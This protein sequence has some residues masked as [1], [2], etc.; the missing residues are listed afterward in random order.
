MLF[1]STPSP[2]PTA[3][4]LAT[5]QPPTTTPTAQHPAQPVVTATD[6]ASPPST[7][8]TIAQPSNVAADQT[9]RNNA[10]SN[11]TTNP[12]ATPS[13]EPSAPAAV[14]QNTPEADE[15]GVGERIMNVLGAFFRP[16]GSALSGAGRM[17]TALSLAQMQNDGVA[18]DMQSNPLLASLFA[19]SQQPTT[20]SP[21]AALAAMNGEV[22][23]PRVSSPSSPSRPNTPQR[24]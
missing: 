6:R 8:A 13:T 20:S 2:T 12:P 19:N 22:N 15:P 17:L 4:V 10:P 16:I 5:V 21:L 23:T 3:P 9:P 1:R 14:A 18:E 11:P 24:A 7:P